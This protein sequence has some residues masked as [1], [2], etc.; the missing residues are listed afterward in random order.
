MCEEF[1]AAGRVLPAGL[2]AEV[3]LSVKLV[4]EAMGQTFGDGVDPLLLSVR[5]GAAVSAAA[6]P[7]V[8]SVVIH[9]DWSKIN[10]T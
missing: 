3:R 1:Y 8:C 6:A 4:E 9:V 2:M 5:S 7:A 10:T